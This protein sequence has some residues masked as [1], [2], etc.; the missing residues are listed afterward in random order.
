MFGICPRTTI[1]GTSLF[2]L[3]RVFPV[4][5][6]L[7]NILSCIILSWREWPFVFKLVLVFQQASLGKCFESISIKYSCQFDSILL[8]IP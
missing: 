1:F 2:G 7:L 5:P 6:A 4:R 3:F 8:L